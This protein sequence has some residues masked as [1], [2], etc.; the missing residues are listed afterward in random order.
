MLSSG[1]EIMRRLAPR[2]K[3][4]LRENALHGVPQHCHQRRPRDLLPMVLLL[5]MKL[6]LVCHIDPSGACSSNRIAVFHVQ[7]QS[8]MILDNKIN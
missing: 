8:L 7:R 4:Q 1:E 3:E 5:M 6:L 2:E